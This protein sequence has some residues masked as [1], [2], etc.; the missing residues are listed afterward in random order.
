MSRPIDAVITWVDGDDPSFNAKRH[1][2]IQS[3]SGMEMRKDIAAPTRYSSIGEIYWCVKGIQT[4]APFVRKIYIVTDGQDPR[5]HDHIPNLNIPVEIIDHKVI[6]RGYE[7]YLPVFNS[8]AIETMLWRIPGLSENFI[9]LNDDFFI[10]APLSIEDWFSTD[11]KPVLYGSN[12]NTLTAQIARRFNWMIK[13]RKVVK[14]RDTMLMAAM[15]PGIEAC[16]FIRLQHL[17]LSM[18]KSLFEEYYSIHPE[19]IIQNISHRF[20]D[21]TQYNPQELNYLLAMRRYDIKP[22]PTAGMLVTM[23]P[24]GERRFNRRFRKLTTLPSV[25]YLCVNSMDLMTDTQRETITGY[26]EQTLTQLTPQ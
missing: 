17:P 6:F 3:S 22:L 5:I 12:Y 13:G 18:K 11:G 25:K 26:L 7:Q 14:F 24:S 16:H 1:K 10:T 23:G 9:Y 2:Y 15:L 4:F 8:L 21:I 19:A 20:R